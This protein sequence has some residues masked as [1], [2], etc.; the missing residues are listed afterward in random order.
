MIFTL[1]TPHY[2]AIMFSI[3]AF[4]HLLFSCFSITPCFIDYAALQCFL[5]LM[6]LDVS[7]FSSPPS[8]FAD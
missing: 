5:R 7:L 3:A 8:L 2:A 4:Y 6:P 1:D